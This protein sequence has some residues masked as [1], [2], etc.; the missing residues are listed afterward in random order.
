MMTNRLLTV[1]AATILSTLSLMAAVSLYR[2]LKLDAEFHNVAAPE[3]A[4]VAD[5]L[6]DI[7]S[8]PAN[9]TPVGADEEDEVER[10]ITVVEGEPSISL[11]RMLRES[12]VRND[13][14]RLNLARNN[15]LVRSKAGDSAT[16]ALVG[17]LLS[18]TD[19]S[20]VALGARILG[21]AATPDCLALLLGAVQAPSSV[22]A[23][24][25]LLDSLSA[26]GSWNDESAFTAS[27]S[28]KLEQFMDT[29]VTDDTEAIRAVTIGLAGLGTATG[30]G[31]IVDLIKQSSAADNKADQNVRVAQRAGADALREIRNPQAVP[32]L[33]RELFNSNSKTAM[34][35]IAGDALAAS[36]LPEATTVLIAW[37]AQARTADQV[38]QA[39]QWLGAVRDPESLELLLAVGTR[40]DFV[41][42][43][44]QKRL[45]EVARHLA[46]ELADA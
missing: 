20:L 36:G 43:E 27:L 44:L 7:S 34:S 31:R 42:G 18:E 4:P 14:F 33:A 23:R 1:L 8:K 17:N 37:A 41:N 2:S 16:L 10:Q 25:I 30:V 29:V 12:A 6:P 11:I 21:E 38:E 28:A 39:V 26:V 9:E 40:A 24:S 32:V 19:M 35:T 46:S 45:A 15:L 3:R 22:A 13:A 5:D